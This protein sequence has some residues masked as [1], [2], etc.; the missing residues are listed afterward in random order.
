MG[1]KEGK[2][3]TGHHHS[4]KTKKTMSDKKKGKRM[5]EKNTSWKGD[6]VTYR[7][8]HKWIEKN[9]GKPT[10]CENC[11]KTG[12]TGK[13]IHWANKNGKYKRIRKDWIR[14]CVS[15]HHILDKTIKNLGKHAKRR[16]T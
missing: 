14:L 4:K 3:F 15:C 8:L 11:G 7:G 5:G 1:H 16:A 10:T 9:F 6:N 2:G 12:L 13:R